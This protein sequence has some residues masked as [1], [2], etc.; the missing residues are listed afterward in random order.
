MLI[1]KAL[2]YGDIIEQILPVEEAL[3]RAINPTIYGKADFEVKFKEGN[4]FITRVMEQP[5]IM[6][7]GVINDFGKSGTDTRTK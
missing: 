7:K 5:K 3:Q 2:N 4:S 1:G 6:I